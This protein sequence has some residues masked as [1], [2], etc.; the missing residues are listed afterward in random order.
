MKKEYIKP[1]LDTKAYAQFESV[2]TDCNKTQSP[3]FFDASFE[4]GAGSSFSSQKKLQG[5]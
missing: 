2:F 4:A 5:A 1:E 3:C